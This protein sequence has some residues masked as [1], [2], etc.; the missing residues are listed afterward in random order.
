MNRAP[1]GNV[2]L[3]PLMLALAAGLGG[4]CRGV[5][6]PVLACSYGGS[7][8]AAG[9]TFPATDGCNT[10]ACNG[11]ATVSCTKVACVDGAAVPTP[12]LPPPASSPAPDAGPSPGPEGPLVATPDAAAPGADASELAVCVVG[13]AMYQPG[14]RFPAEDG[15]NTC[16]CLAGGQA[17]C[18]RIGCPPVCEL[19]ARYEYGD[20]GGLRLFTERS[21]LEPGNR[22]SRV[23]SPVVV[24]TPLLSCAPALPACGTSG[25]ITASEIE[26]AFRHPDVRSALAEA[27]PPLFGRDTRPVDGT[28][29]EV[30]R[31]D[32]RGVLIGQGCASPN[33]CRAIPA[34]VA[35][36]GRLL[37]ELDR[38][39][40]AAPEC[41]VLGLR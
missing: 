28:V 16:T 19:A 4:A 7:E 24:G 2:R 20:I 33:G 30:K 39:Q 1:T 8:H 23:R 21:F 9:S 37:R 25:A 3:I 13:S 5:D 18:T 12:A 10:C 31:A 15:C 40:L 34:G 11:D 32:G 29:L 35:Q 36:L 22:Y 6:P 27:A 41:Q 38:Q 17:A 26:G 14:E